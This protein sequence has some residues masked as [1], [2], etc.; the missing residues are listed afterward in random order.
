MTSLGF[1]V[2]T[3]TSPLVRGYVLNGGDR[4]GGRGGGLHG[5]GTVV[6]NEAA[7]GDGIGDKSAQQCTRANCVVVT[8]DHVVNHVGVAVGIHHRNDRQTQ[9]AGFGHGDV[10]LLRVDDEDRVGHAVKVRDAR[11]VAVE[12]LELAAVTQR[13]ALGHAL[14]VAGLLHA[15]QLHHALDAP[16][17]SGEVGEH[18]T[19]PALVDEGHSAGVRVVRDR[20]LS[21]L[22][23][24]HEEDD[25]A[26]GDEVADVGVTLLNAREGLA[27]VN[28]VDAV[29]LAE[30]E[31]THLG[32]PTTSLVSEM[33]AGVKEFLQSDEGH[34]NFLP[35][36]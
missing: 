33:D 9:L 6:A 20:A 19:Q 28:Q 32:I 31:A 18:A 11:K 17:H 12:L 22:L 25:A 27:Q 30:D 5:G 34:E 4:G 24:A 21:L 36:G 29:A 26:F 7:L 2:Y 13:L 10:F 15:P 35:F 3:F 14:E 16:G 8:G 23:G 1:A